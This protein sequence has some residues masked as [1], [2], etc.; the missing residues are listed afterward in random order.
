VAEPLQKFEGRDPNFWE[1][2]VDETGDEE[3]N[4]HSVPPLAFISRAGLLGE[5]QSF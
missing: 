4:A 2:S 5:T 3:P 1:E